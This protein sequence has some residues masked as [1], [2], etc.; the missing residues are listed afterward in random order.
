MVANGY[1][2]VVLSA[3]LFIYSFT[4]V[5]ALELRNSSDVKV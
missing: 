2:Q 1:C 4:A 3:P 5:K